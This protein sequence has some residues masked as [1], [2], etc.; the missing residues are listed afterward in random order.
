[1]KKYFLKLELKT[2]NKSI[3]LIYNTFLQNLFLKLNIFYKKFFL[4][5]KKKKITLLKSPH[6]YKKAREQFELTSFKQIFLL[7]SNYT[8]IFLKFLLINKP[9][10]INML[11]KK[12]A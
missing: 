12:I 8:T 7:S 4:P 5:I 3:L 10:E 2:L 6:V 9:S 1:M 11:L